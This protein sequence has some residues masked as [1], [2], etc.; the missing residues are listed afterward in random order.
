MFPALAAVMVALPTSVVGIEPGS[1]LQAELIGQSRANAT[2]EVEQLLRVA[3]QQDLAGDNA[4]AIA[5]YRQALSL[6]DQQAERDLRLKA[7]ALYGLG[8]AYLATAQYDLALP[9]L[10]AALAL[11]QSFAATMADSTEHPDQVNDAEILISLFGAIG[12]I[13]HEQARFVT[14]LTYYQQ[15]VGGEDSAAQVDLLH[16]IG[17]LQAEIGQ[18]AEAE[19]SLQSAVRLSQKIEYVEGEASVVFALGWVYERQQNYPR[20]TASYLA[21]IDLFERIDEPSR[22]I[23]AFNNLSAVS[24]QQQDYAAAKAALDSGFDLLKADDDPFERGV[25]LNSL[26]SF[27]Q[28]VEKFDLAWEQSFL[29]LQLS[30]Q[31]GNPVS[32]IAVLRN[33]GEL[34]VAQAQPDLAIFFYKQ[35]IA[36]IET[37]REE[38][39]QFPQS[40]QQQYRMTIEDLYRDL[41][42]LLLRQNRTGE[43]LQILDLLKLQ[44]VKAYLHNDQADGV[45]RQATFNTPAEAALAQMLGDLPTD[46]SLTDFVAS[47]AA[48][49]LSAAVET[50]AD[51]SFELQSIEN[52]QAALA[53][54]PVK[55][56]ALYPLILSDR[57]EVILITPDGTLQ[58]YT[59]VITK[60][61]LVQTVG[62]LQR[63]LSTDVND[64]RP[65]AGQLYDWLIRPLEGAL[66]DSEIENI[67]YLPDGVLRYVPIATLYDGQ[68]WFAEK[69][70]SH[71]ITAAALGDLT[72]ENSLPLSVLAGAFTSDIAAYQVHIG[73][74]TYTYDGLSA[75]KQEIQNL[76][77]AIPDTVAL[78][79]RAFTPASLL[80]A[81][82][83]HRIVHLATHAKFVPGQPE[84][85]FILFG[86]GSTVNMRDIQQWRL[87]DVDLV[88]FSACQTGASIEGDGKEILGLGFQVHQMGAGAAIASLWSVD[89]AAT[90]ALM[91]E[92][93]RALSAGQSKAQAL[94]QAQLQLIKSQRFSHPYDWAAFILIGNGL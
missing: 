28:A 11:Y 21:A 80:N 79:D 73:Q 57:L 42:D 25:L 16:N 32:E 72:E 93:Y 41:A 18:F 54:Q 3:D 51:E 87:P 56:A 30:R 27:Y 36:Q 70:Q 91:S 29:A 17:S 58:N 62:D 76:K 69:Y 15:G 2:G 6:I 40:A 71:N 59:T 92:F 86:D 48:I 10:E 43:A 33:L 39:Q 8:Y 94:Q 34:M 50:S 13:Y 82:G 44:E 7:K 53:A 67:I 9:E 45:R 89:D 61:E 37:I 46:I 20:A 35:A 78:L 90:A 5:S 64:P 88:V 22:Q 75:A 63:K 23:R 12:A 55:T 24:L 85:S 14:A 26:G 84:E 47:T 38:L 4:G 74:Q 1:G 65:A 52:L 81:V 49:A 77:N 19:I 68:Q 66:A 60:A 31:N 83:S